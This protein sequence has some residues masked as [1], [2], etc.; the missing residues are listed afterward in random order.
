MALFDLFGQ[1]TFVA[2][3]SGTILTGV[4]GVWTAMY[5]SN[6]RSNSNYKKIQDLD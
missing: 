3:R 5:E 2:H 6:Q 4:D 1:L